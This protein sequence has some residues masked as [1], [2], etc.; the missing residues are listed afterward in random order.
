MITIQ[1]LSCWEEVNLQINFY[2]KFNFGEL[3]QAKMHQQARQWWPSGWNE[4]KMEDAA[5]A[6]S[7]FIYL[8]PL[9]T[10]RSTK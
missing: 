7:K 9:S 5:V 6:V 2:V 3:W 1:G 10:N 4:S 8:S